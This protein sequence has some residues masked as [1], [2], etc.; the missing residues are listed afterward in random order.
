VTWG[1]MRHVLPALAP[2]LALALAGAAVT[3]CYAPATTSP[4]RTG[5]GGPVVSYYLSLGDSLSQG[6]QPNS[7]GASVQTRNGYADQLYSALRRHDA[8]LRLV[9]LGCPGETTGTM[10]KGGICSY[11]GGSQLTAAVSFLRTHQ[12]RVSLITIDIGGNDPGSC[13]TR[14]SIRNLASC[15][16][17]FVP[18]ATAN[19]TTVMTRL[20]EAAGH[21]RIIG[22]NY[23][24]PVLAEW[25]NGTAGQELARISARLA[26]GY[27]G[28]LANVYKASGAA[29]ADVFATFHTADF[30]HQVALA[31]FGNLPRNVAAICQWT[32]ECAPPPRGPNQHANQAGYGA[33]ARAFLL[34]GLPVNAGRSS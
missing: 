26:A 32:W 6:V 14:P 10:I 7:A 33:I 21:A 31:G 18:E 16:A 15:I 12:G 9:K 29:V 13:V 23:Y 30:G 5:H 4:P 27:N 34:A 25:R 28:L 20:R 24:L 3:S 22:M 17:R 11:P 19:L 8:G 2:A 1:A